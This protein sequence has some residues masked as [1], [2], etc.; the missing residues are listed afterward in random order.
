LTDGLLLI[1]YLFGF[2]GDSLVQGALGDGAERNT[3]EEIETYLGE[4]MPSE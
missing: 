2:T 1:R 4:R 3:A